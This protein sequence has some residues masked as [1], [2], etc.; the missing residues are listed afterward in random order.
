MVV[1][2]YSAYK[3]L[4]GFDFRKQIS[5][6]S[7]IDSAFLSLDP[8]ISAVRLI[9]DKLS[10][11]TIDFNNFLTVDE[12]SIKQQFISRFKSD[13][14]VSVWIGDDSVFHSLDEISASDPEADLQGAGLVLLSKIVFNEYTKGE[15][16]NIFSDYKKVIPVDFSTI[17]TDAE[18]TTDQI[19]V[20]ILFRVGGNVYFI[21]PSSAKLEYNFNINFA[22]DFFF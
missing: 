22:G 7:E 17:K 20:Y 3:T 6:K 1:D 15:N 19:S 9:V 11:I 8:D 16:Y 13:S 2:D 12:Q 14:S 21:N 4:S 5:G 18:I 10:T